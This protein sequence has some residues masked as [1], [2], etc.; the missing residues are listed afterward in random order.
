MATITKS[1]NLFPTELVPQIFNKVAGHSTLAKLSKQ[2]PIP[3][4]GNQ[5]FVFT[6][7]G[8]ASI[9]GEGENKPAGDAGFK[10]VTIKPIKFIY[11]SRVTDEFVNMSEEKQVPYLQAFTEG[12]AKKIARALDIAAMHGVNPATGTVYAGISDKNFDMATV[13]SV[14][15]TA[16][17]EDD[18]L[19]AAIQTIVASDGAITGIAMAPSFGSDL[20]KIKVNGVVQYPEFRFGGNPG[21]FASIPSD[22]NNT[23][24]FKE[25][26]DLAIVGD[27]ANAFKWGFA[28]NVPMEV[29][30]YGDPDG[31][32]DLKRT[33][34]ICLRAEAYIG[35]GILDTDSFKKIVKAEG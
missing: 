33:N 22:V 35:W 2:E 27:F 23:V 24:S 25:S 5:E 11:Q 26:K 1:T 9:V 34:Q 30:E 16:G 28:E 21:T 12:F 32:G 13:G 7:D 4:T 15:V 18:T 6:M 29:I 3:F 19:D 31:L 20:A 14:T 10:P 17:S 8:E